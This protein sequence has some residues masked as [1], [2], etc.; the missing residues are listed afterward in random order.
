MVR[1]SGQW[2][3]EQ[4]LALLEALRHQ[5]EVRFR[6][7][8]PAEAPDDPVLRHQYFQALALA[9]LASLLPLCRHHHDRLHADA[10]QLQLRDDRSL[11]VRRHGEV[12]MTTGPPSTQWA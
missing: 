10:W 3:P 7:Q 9:D 12:I 6:G 8:H 5:T 2:D 11:V 1:M 4:G